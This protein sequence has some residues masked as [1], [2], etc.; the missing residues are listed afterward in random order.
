MICQNV[1]VHYQAKLGSFSSTIFYLDANFVQNGVWKKDRLRITIKKKFPFQ[2]YY[3]LLIFYGNSDCN[4]T[5]FSG[6]QRVGVL[7]LSTILK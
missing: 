2:G 5:I 1:T 4:N 3:L 6:S 7:F